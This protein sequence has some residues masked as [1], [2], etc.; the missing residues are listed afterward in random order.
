VH[1][2]PPVAELVTEPLDDDRPVV[3]DMTGGFAL[4]GEVSQ[5][6][7]DRPLVESETAEQLRRLGCV[8]LLQVAD[9]RA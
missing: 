3:R 8:E 9:E 7:G 4:L 1:G 5:R 2:D 6:V